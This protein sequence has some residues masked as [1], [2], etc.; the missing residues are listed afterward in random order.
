M[1]LSVKDISS[2][3]FVSVVAFMSS[4]LIY[5]CIGKIK[6]PIAGRSSVFWYVGGL[7]P[8]RPSFLASSAPLVSVS[9]P[10]AA[11]SLLGP[12]AD[13]LARQNYFR[14]QNLR[15]TSDLMPLHLVLSSFQ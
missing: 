7:H 4:P 8:F 6:A 9:T 11:S 10:L 12:P 14:H 13:A 3:F 15:W 2:A 1:A 5:E